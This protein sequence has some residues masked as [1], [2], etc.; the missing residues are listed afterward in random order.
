M[1]GTNDEVT[2]G[3]L[4]TERA[5]HGIRELILHQRLRAGERTSVA[6]LA[7]RMNLGRTPVKEAITR[8]MAEGLMTVHDR[9]GTFV[10]EPT[11][12]DMRDMFAMRKLLEGHAAG[13]AVKRVTSDQLDELDQLVARMEAESL[14]KAPSARSLSLFLEM[15]VELHRRIVGLAGN[16]TLSRLY[17][18]L[19]LD[20]QIAT[21]LQRHGPSMA[22]DRHR[23]HV[24]MMEALGARDGAR[25]GRR[26]FEH[27]DAVEH[28]VLMSMLDV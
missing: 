8:L 11:P 21:Y 5:Y 13:E 19:N 12:T 10:H 15:D 1:A 23:E 27:V 7:D 16:A 4:A 6:V 28:V 20:L 2:R 17:A 18:S 9:R 24:A 14:R 3:P 25:L 22:I 26:M